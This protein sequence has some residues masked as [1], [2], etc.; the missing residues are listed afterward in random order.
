MDRAALIHQ[1]EDAFEGIQLGTGIGIHQAMAID[2]YSSDKEIERAKRLDCWEDW[3]DIPDHVMEQGEAALCFMDAKG[4]L[5]AL[6]AYMRY[7]VRYFDTSGWTT[8]DSAVY[9]LERDLKPAKGVCELMN[10]QQK[11]V[12]ARFLRFVVLDTGDQADSRIASIA[13]EKHWARYD[14]ES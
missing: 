3:R 6:P 12:V 10:S 13:Y 9:A 7:C 5:F 1:I 2:A 11:A 4:I 14:P 8:V